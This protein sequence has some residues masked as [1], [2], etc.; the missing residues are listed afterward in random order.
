MPFSYIELYT[1][2][3]EA[4]NASDFPTALGNTLHRLLLAS[5]SGV[6]STWRIWCDINKSIKDF[7]ENTRFQITDTDDLQKVPWGQPAKETTFDEY[8]KTKYFVE[9]FERAFGIPW[10]LLR[11]D[12][13]GA[14]RQIPRKLGR[15]GAR[16]VAKFAIALLES[17]TA[18]TGVTTAFSETALGAAITEFENRVDPR[19]GEPIGVT[20]KYIIYPPAIE[21]DVKRVLNSQLTIAVGVGNAAA[22]MGNY[23]PVNA[24]ETHLTPLK[25]PF[26][27][28]SKNWYLAAAP[29]DTPGIE[30]GFL[31][32]KDQPQIFTQACDIQELASVFER[33]MFHSGA[34]NYKVCMDFG[35]V[36]VD[37]NAL[38]KVNA[39]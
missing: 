19:S 13:V 9:T 14:I 37:P 17:I 36:V 7:K 16:T 6:N 32:G 3:R 27:T 35:G 5:Y 10:Q 39:E 21:T 33:G 31:D 11:N 28:S 18:S 2:L 15:A 38:L 20:P 4:G 24:N 29:S 22:V 30:M 25:E 1:K 12:D 34:I 23:N 26:L 8:N